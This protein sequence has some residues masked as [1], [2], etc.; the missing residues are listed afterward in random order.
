M[1]TLK[2]DSANTI[3]RNG[4]FQNSIF[5]KI[6]SIPLIFFGGLY[7]FIYTILGFF[8]ILN[9]ENMSVVFSRWLH[10]TMRLLGFPEVRIIG[11]SDVPEMPRAKVYV[12]NHQ[13]NWDLVIYAKMV[14]PR[15]YVLGKKEIFWIPIF[16]QF[17]FLAGNFL[18]DRSSKEAG[19]KC[20]EAMNKRIA[21]KNHSL[22]VFPEGTRNK[23]LDTILRPFKIGAFK[24]AKDTGA[25][26]AP[27]LSLSAPKGRSSPIFLEYLDPIDPN[28]F[29]DAESLMTHTHKIMLDHLKSFLSKN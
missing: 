18:I 11:R 17:F 16:G 6:L 25:Y 20:I 7:A 13:S 28:D 27:V 23:D 21:K 14:P 22:F 9:K 24:I 1:S 12:G 29:A 15:T 8:K 5:L 10:S 19:K 4:Y 26:I 2:S 3:Q